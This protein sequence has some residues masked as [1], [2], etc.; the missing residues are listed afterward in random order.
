MVS[1][2]RLMGSAAPVR[3][4]R[5]ASTIWMSIRPTRL[6]STTKGWSVSNWAWTRAAW[7]SGAWM[8]P[9]R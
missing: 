2:T 5:R 6:L 1:M 9:L 3:S 8:A 7:M 4:P